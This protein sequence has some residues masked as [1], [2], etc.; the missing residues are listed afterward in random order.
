[1]TTQEINASLKKIITQTSLPQAVR[2]GLSHLRH[3]YPHFNEKQL[4]QKIRFRSNPSL[5]F[6]KSEI[7]S[8]LLKYN[9]DG[10]YL[11]F[12]LNFLGIFGSSSPLPSHYSEMVLQDL[13][14]DGALRDYLDLFNHH[15]EKF[16]Y[17]I[18]E[19]HRHYVRYSHDLKDGY[20]KYVLS[21][22]GLFDTHEKNSNGLNIHKLLPF[23]GTLMIRQKSSEMILPILRHYLDHEEIEIEQCIGRNVTIP[24]WQRSRLGMNNCILGK[25]ML[26]GNE[27]H[28]KNTKFR[29]LLRCASWDELENYST[30]GP[31]MKEL[32]LLMDYLLQEPLAY[33]V[34]LNIDSSEVKPWELTETN[35][36]YLG[37]NSVLGES[38]LSLNIL[39]M[40]KG[41]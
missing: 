40:S 38:T 12:T 10:A 23:L 2:I 35:S 37:I 6:Q 30:Y 34:M 24:M 16:I 4:Y 8:A 15:L 9:D 19:K 28:S 27:V 41:N 36:S 18:W 22:M 5:S 33:E 3:L 21:L 25:S 1:M 13:D 26:A 14:S 17:P 29:I 11:E 20:S 7:S 31:K 32:E 39:F